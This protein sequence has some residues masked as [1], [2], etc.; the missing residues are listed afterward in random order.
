MLPTEF[1]TSD[2]ATALGCPRMLAQKAAYWL[3][4]A[5]LIE[6]VGFAGNAIIYSKV[7]P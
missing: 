5:G 1:L 2:I 3:R 6:Q 7:V 4:N